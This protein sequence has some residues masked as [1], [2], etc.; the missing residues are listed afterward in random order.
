M[1]PN[2]RYFSLY[3]IN[4]LERDTWKIWE[5]PLKS[6]DWENQPYAAS[7]RYF[8]S[9]EAAR[10]QGEEAFRRFH[11]T[12]VRTRHRD[13]QGL[14]TLE[15]ILAAA[16]KTELDLMRFQEDLTDPSCL[17]RLAEDHTVALSKGVFG[18]P[19][20]VFP[21]AEP[22]YLKLGRV[23]TP[24]ESLDFW[25]AFRTMVVERPYVLEIKRPQ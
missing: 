2:W 22:A 15:T 21:G 10:R 12:L 14:A 19:T 4:H 5:Q 6:P 17:E 18:T 23:I 8:W 13:K 3:Q 7:L 11:L 9:A 25:E 24:E 20:F 1:Q 16:Q